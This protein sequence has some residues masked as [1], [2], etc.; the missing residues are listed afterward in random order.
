M[1]KEIEVKWLKEKRR[2]FKLSEDLTQTFRDKILNN[3]VFPK[4]GFH[5]FNMAFKE[6]QEVLKL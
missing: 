1:V 3:C 4:L 6:K 5:I 2:D